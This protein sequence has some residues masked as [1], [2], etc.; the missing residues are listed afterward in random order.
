MDPRQAR[1]M[2]ILMA[3]LLLAAGWSLIDSGR[4]T[5][6][7]LGNF[8]DLWSAALGFYAVV[9]I[10][11]LTALAWVYRNPESTLA[12]IVNR[13]NS[14]NSK[15]GLSRWFLLALL[16][17]LQVWLLL[18]PIGDRL[19]PLPLRFL[20]F[21]LSAYLGALLLPVEWG[22]F[23]ARW[24]MA[25]MLS[26]LS[27]FV[28][29]ELNL[30]RPYPFKLTW[31]EGNRIWDYS[32]YFGQNRYRIEGPL[33]YPSYMAPGRHGLWGLA[34]LVPGLEIWGARFWNAVLWIAPALLLSWT[35]LRRL[36]DHL[37][38]GMRV[39]WITWAFL[40]LSQGPIYAPLIL[41]AALL[42][43]GYNADRPYR[44]GLVVALAC[45]YAGTSR[46]TWMATPALWAGLWAT[47]D[48]DKQHVWWRRVLWPVGL[49]LIGLAGGWVS[50]VAVDALHPS[51]GPVFAT[52]FSQA[53]LWYR[54]F[55]SATNPIG[56]LA[57]VVLAT[58]P[59]LA[60]LGVA[61]DRKW[62]RLDGLESVAIGAVLLSTFAVGLVA[63][64]KIGG[65][66]N[67]H[68]LDMFL[69][70]LVITTALLLHR[71]DWKSAQRQA[72][73]AWQAILALI[74]FIPVGF[75]LQGGAPLRL[76]VQDDVDQS[77]AQI[78]EF[79]EQAAVDGEIL[80]IDQ[81]Q[82]LTFGQVDVPMVVEY[83]L[84]DLTNKAMIGDPQLFS[85]FYDD[86]RSGR[87]SVIVTGHLPNEWRGRGH[88]FGEEDDAQL[89][90][91]Y[92]P[93]QQYYRPAIQLNE[94]GIWLL[95]PIDS[96]SELSNGSGATSQ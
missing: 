31:S 2:A 26:A 61:V 73:G 38:R 50:Q 64:V 29:K 88:P 43:W 55:P 82:L 10:L 24:I 17:G 23:Q 93:L 62:I 3:A 6:H 81:R 28:G 92:L 58:G 71:L 79:I 66:N 87:F 75:N 12:P 1:W 42:A 80:F 65:G 22:S 91:I 16:L 30:V 86:L 52:S 45:F 37:T 18:G 20:L 7:V 8:S 94:V 35:L 68:N 70:S 89:E 27:F 32:L 90:F 76:P 57:G 74:L 40:F 39:L 4:G 96:G 85:D 56:I 44:T 83:E 14:L 77:V 33:E 63:S 41:A 53:L 59:L 78:Q 9:L 13:L 21:T 72:G 51:D 69:V 95:V 46:W 5:G 60:G 54:L 48:S 47:L 67:L 19:T 15:L 11:G 49:G 25:L 36:P 84:K 34:F